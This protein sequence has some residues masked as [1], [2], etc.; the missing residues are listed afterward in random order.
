MARHLSGHLAFFPAV[1]DRIEQLGGLSTEGLFRIPGSNDVVA[2]LLERA[3][4]AGGDVAAIGDVLK[5][6]TDVHDAAS[7][8]S[9]WLREENALIPSS[10]F[11][12][13]GEVAR[14]P[15]PRVVLRQGWLE[16]KG[17]KTI[18]G[19]DNALRKE[20]HYHK[21]GRRN[22]K[23]RYFILYDGGELAVYAELPEEFLRSQVTSEEPQLPPDEFLKST[24][25]LTAAGECCSWQLVENED[26]E[27]QNVLL[28]LPGPA[29][30]DDPSSH[31]VMQL[32]T[33]T[34]ADAEA[35]V[36]ASI[37]AVGAGVGM[38]AAEQAADADTVEWVLP[39]HAEAVA[40]HAARREQWE[41]A[42]AASLPQRCEEC[43]AALPQPG[44]QLLRSLVAFLQKVDPVSTKMTPSNLGMVFG[45]SVVRREDPMESF[46]NVEND[47]QFLMLLIEHLQPVDDDDVAADESDDEAAGKFDDER[48][49]AVFKTMSQW[50]REQRG[51]P[52]TREE[53]LDPEALRGLVSGL[54]KDTAELLT[55]ATAMTVA[56]A[57]DTSLTL[58]EESL[59][60]Q[61]HHQVCRQI[62]ID[63]IC[64]KLLERFRYEVSVREITH[65]RIDSPTFQKISDKCVGFDRE[66][67][68]LWVE[69]IWLHT[70]DL[71][72][73][74]EGAKQL[75]EM[76]CDRLQALGVFQLAL[77]MEEHASW[78]SPVEKW[79]GVCVFA[80]EP[81][82]ADAVRQD[83]LKC[84]VEVLEVLPPDCKA[85]VGAELDFLLKTAAP[86]DESARISSA[87]RN[88]FLQGI[89]ATWFR[90][91]QTDLVVHAVFQ[92]FTSQ[93]LQAHAPAQRSDELPQAPSP[94]SGGGVQPKPESEP[95]S[96]PEPEPEPEPGTSEQRMVSEWGQAYIYS[97][98]FPTLVPEHGFAA[99]PLHGW[100]DLPTRQQIRFTPDERAHEHLP[101]G[102]L[103]ELTLTPLTASQQEVQALDGLPAWRSETQCRCVAQTLAEVFNARCG[104]LC[105]PVH[106]GKP[107]VLH[108]QDRN[109][110]YAAER[111][112][113]FLSSMPTSGEEARSAY[114]HLSYEASAKRL[115]VVAAQGK[116]CAVHTCDHAGFGARNRGRDG[117]RSFLQGHVCNHLCKAMGL[118]QLPEDG[119][120]QIPLPLGWE[121][122]EGGWFI[123]HN[124]RNF[125]GEDPRYQPNQRVEYL[126]FTHGNQ[127]LKA[128]VR[129]SNPDG[130]V[131]LDLRDNAVTCRIRKPMVPNASKR[132]RLASAQV[133]E[134]LER[135]SGYDIADSTAAADDG[136]TR[137]IPEGV[138]PQGDSGSASPAAVA[139]AVRGWQK[140]TDEEEDDYVDVTGLWHCQAEE[141]DSP[142]E[143][144]YLWLEQRGHIVEGRDS[145]QHG[146]PLVD[147]TRSDGT[148]AFTCR[149]TIRKQTAGA[150][151]RTPTGA[152]SSG[153]AA[154]ASGMRLEL[155][156][157]S[158]ADGANGVSTATKWSGIVTRTA[159]G[160]LVY[161]GDWTG[162]ASGSLLGRFLAVRR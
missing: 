51:K 49:Q 65:K 61:E 150:I 102:S 87:V 133:G 138:P 89:V 31:R 39:T 136:Q 27:H 117:M 29:A 162:E 18:R 105:L 36:H 74:P 56:G 71:D 54:P 52:L 37:E 86:R 146:Q 110:W 57:G 94:N 79:Q 28:T 21:G 100:K 70:N 2:E 140:P 99:H 121:E 127:Y 123:D 111:Q 55:A 1:C 67:A 17:G 95:Q 83:A 152:G 115:V 142:D 69:T 33:E 147:S 9:K 42:C 126:S 139:S 59:I 6:C 90:V 114:S 161:E 96:E 66:A 156:Q 26:S 76:L 101:D 80:Q 106:F 122:K 19:P 44:R 153:V 154:S 157:E 91:E 63:S 131:D 16:K 82:S 43:L 107:Y 120:D 148:A 81:V 73:G 30:D 3:S 4:A 160:G 124:T 62:G 119:P 132:A 46:K 14:P 141:T 108:M 50:S 35:W 13:C 85:R 151:E 11:Q 41:A 48:Q 155:V 34:R 118:P 25:Q 113:G 7:L 38:A 40:A 77:D 97:G 64:A 10:E 109:A 15:P 84:A 72:R 22:W 128:V 130:T 144:E 116:D 12:R 137:H 68:L 24:E 20:R 5:D 129:Q 75:S 143:S 60:P 8:L 23:R 145:D 103:I 92:D 32:R 78:N 104:N 125:S 58:A 47:K 53:F 98:S 134:L 45:I 88:P 112:W 93:L 159:E 149:G 158:A 135:S